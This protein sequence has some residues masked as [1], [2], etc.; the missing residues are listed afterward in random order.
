M[1]DT[2]C[3]NPGCPIGRNAILVAH[4]YIRDH[5]VTFGEEVM[6]FSASVEVPD[7]DGIKDAAVSLDSWIKLA[8]G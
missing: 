2:C 8:A 5:I 4:G 3:G 7:I 1:S 6:S